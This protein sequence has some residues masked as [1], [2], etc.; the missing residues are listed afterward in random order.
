MT[1]YCNNTNKSITYK[2]WVTSPVKVTES[3]LQ[4]LHSIGV[5]GRLNNS[6]N[7][8]FESGGQRYYYGTGGQAEFQTTCEKQELMLQLMYGKDLLLL[9]VDVVPPHS[10]MHT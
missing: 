7:E 9:R 10:I 5:T 4:S 2:T 1:S 8:W 6:S 3:H